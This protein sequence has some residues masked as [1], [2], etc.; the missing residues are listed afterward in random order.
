MHILVTGGAG[1]IGSH[2]VLELLNQNYKVTVVDNLSNSS[3]ESL[4][5]VEKLTGKNIDFHELDLRDRESLDILFADNTFDAVV[6]F[7]GLKAV[8]ESV[9][10]ALYYYHNNLVSTLTLLEIMELYKVK[11]FV[12][13]SSAT[14]YGN[15]K[16]VPIKETAP[17]SATNPY[18]QTKLIIE[19]IL[20]DIVNT[21]QDWQITSLRYFN[22]I[23]AHKSGDIGEDPN[24]IPNN[25]LPFIS[26]VAI[27]KL[28]E[29]S[30]FGNDYPTPDG[31]CIRDYIHVVDL[32]KAHIAAIKQPAKPNKYQVYNIGTGNG[33]SVLQMLDAFKKASGQKI[34]FKIAPRRPGDIAQCFSDVTKANQELGWKAQKSI[35]QACQD[36]WRWQSKNPNGY[37]IAG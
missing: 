23:G 30:V 34:P 8:G 14:V 24:G 36:A 16:T 12:F 27:G 25:L 21:N 2:T 26:Q 9:N 1:Y 13:S 29:F 28:K 5:R 22:P 19:Q 37:I 15:P 3:I 17:K 35:E 11:N 6:H 20:E 4:R 33:Y 10:K 7:A 32:A 31:T 18:G